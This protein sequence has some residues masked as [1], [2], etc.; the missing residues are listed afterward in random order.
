MAL[1]GDGALGRRG[2][3]VQSVVLLATLRVS[4]DV[5]RDPR[6]A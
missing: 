5:G 6:Y 4:G 2:G 1:R 3:I